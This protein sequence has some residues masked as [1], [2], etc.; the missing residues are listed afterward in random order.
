[1]AC[2]VSGVK[3]RRSGGF[4]SCFTRSETGTSPCLIPTLMPSCFPHH[5]TLSWMSRPSARRGDTYKARMPCVFFVCRSSDKMGKSAASV[6]PYPVGA[7]I[8][9][10]SPLSKLGIANCWT[11]V[12]SPNR[13]TARSRTFGCNNWKAF[14]SRPIKPRRP[15]PFA[16]RILI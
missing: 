6:F 8:S 4:L 2:K 7:R 16:L 14:C 1:M 13:P 5:N 11:S 10:F 9:A 15:Y 3:T 12:G